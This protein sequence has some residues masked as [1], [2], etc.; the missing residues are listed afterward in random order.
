ME[1]VFLLLL[2]RCW[3][4]HRSSL[5]CGYVVIEVRPLFTVELSWYNELL[6]NVQKL[7]LLSKRG[8]LW[9]SLNLISSSNNFCIV[10]FTTIKMLS[11]AKKA[12]YNR[13][14]TNAST[15]R[16]LCFSLW[17]KG[18]YLAENSW[19]ESGEVHTATGSF[20]HKVSFHNA[21]TPSVPALISAQSQLKYRALPS[22]LTRV[23]PFTPRR[24]GIWSF[25][26]GKNSQ[27]TQERVLGA[28]RGLQVLVE[29][30]TVILLLSRTWEAWE[31]SLISWRQRGR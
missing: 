31:Q 18:C 25:C 27:G 14:I 10:Q 20:A 6:F 12:T 24:L 7:L 1:I 21:L 15:V 9:I 3:L 29:L 13:C 19:C 8:C 2:S 22:Q 16:R 11:D 23:Q 17:Q 28:E 30:K 26:W 5:T 4:L